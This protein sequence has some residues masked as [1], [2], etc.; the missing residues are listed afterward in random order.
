MAPVVPT[1]TAAIAV[2]GAAPPV[3]PEAYAA[4]A[5]HQHVPSGMQS[6]NQTAEFFLS[7]YRLGKTL[8]IGS[9]G[10]VPCP[11]V[12]LMVLIPCRG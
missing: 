10:K 6:A 12:A 1:G 8:G 3:Q 9:F 11:A 5:Q 4:A 2:P 7:N